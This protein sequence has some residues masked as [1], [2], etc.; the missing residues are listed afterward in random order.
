MTLTKIPKPGGILFLLLLISITG[1]SQDKAP[2]LTGIVVAETGE[3]LNGVSVFI[4]TAGGKEARSAMSNEKGIFSFA[5]LK[6]NTRYNLSF[7]YVGY[8]DT[9]VNQFELKANEENSLMVRMRKSVSSLN[10]IVVTP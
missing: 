7:S 2:G 1:F 10:E 3:S 4:R 8:T 9:S 5:N 6:L